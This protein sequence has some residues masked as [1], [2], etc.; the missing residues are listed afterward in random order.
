[1]KD[2]DILAT[3]IFEPGTFAGLDS[4][5][6]LH[7]LWEAKDH[8]AFL[9]EIG[10]RIRGMATGFATGAPAS[11]I[12]KL[13]RLEIIANFGVGYEKVDVEHARRKGIRVTNT[14]DVLTEEVADLALALWLSVSRRLPAAE[15]Y[16]RAGKWLLGSFPLATSIERRK[17]GILGMGRIGQAIA[18]RAQLFEAEIRYFQPRPRAEVTF[19]HIA[20]PV[21]LAG[22]ADVLFVAT[23]GGEKTRG[24]VDRTIID[25]LGAKGTLI[26]IA[27]GSV[28]D[29]TALVAA[30]VEGRLGAAGLD[31]FAAEPRVP[32]ALLGLENVVLLPHVGSAT[33]ETRRAMGQ[34]V[35]DNLV[36]YFSGRPLLTP[37]V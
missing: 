8:D 9:A 27:R 34:L 14:P 15:R 33:V 20:D 24:L 30:L 5:F 13:P 37:I 3:H 35:I 11:L 22:W 16:L 26:N 19:P 23:P 31:V 7:R 36:A 6:T 2:V 28:V 29:E 25:A 1:M 4:A 17:V 21:A 12:D 18:R 10:D 32:E